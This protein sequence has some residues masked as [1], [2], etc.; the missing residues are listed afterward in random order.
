M[1]RRPR[2]RDEAI[3]DRT[4]ILISIVQGLSVLAGVILVYFSCLNLGRSEA[5]TR[6]LSFFTLVIGN[7][8][9][10]LINRSSLKPQ[11]SLVVVF[12]VVCLSLVLIMT[13]PYLKKMFYFS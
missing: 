11:K 4:R 3:L 9:L 10:T 8:I 5:E 12:L 6:F 1:K 7:F 13:V 2:Q